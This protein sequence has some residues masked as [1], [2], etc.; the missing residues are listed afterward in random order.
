MYVNTSPREYSIGRLL[1][2]FVVIV[3]VTAVASAAA[4][5]TATF[6]SALGNINSNSGEFFEVLGRYVLFGR[7]EYEL[8][9]DSFCSSHNQHDCIA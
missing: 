1:T 4:M 9:V 3:A 8:L 5:Q 6:Y 7:V 2:S